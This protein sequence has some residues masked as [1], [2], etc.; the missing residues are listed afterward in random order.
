MC[1]EHDAASA[2]P[3]WQAAVRFAMQV[4]RSRPLGVA[5]VALCLHSLLFIPL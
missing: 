2:A 5:G 3:I 1:K 4:R